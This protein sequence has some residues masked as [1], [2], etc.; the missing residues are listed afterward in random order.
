MGYE[1]VGKILLTSTMLNKAIIDANKSVREFAKL[2]EVDFDEMVSGEKH[3]IEAKFSDGS[4]SRINFYRVNNA[5]G[6]RR[7]SI[8]GI[9]SHAS[10]GDI[11]IIAMKRNK[12]VID[13][14]KQSD[15]LSIDEEELSN[16]KT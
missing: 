11:V 7:V 12:V 3:S 8:K 13:V 16:D 6:D 5:R 15:E 2:C 9:K 4:E 10:V 1:V 14:F